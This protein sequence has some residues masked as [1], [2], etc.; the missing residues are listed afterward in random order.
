MP[1]LLPAGVFALEYD[2]GGT[3]YNGTDFVSDETTSDTELEQL[4]IL[5]L[6]FEAYTES[7][8]GVSGLFTAQGRYEYT[9]DRA[10]LFDIDVLKAKGKFPGALGEDS[11]LEVE[12]GRTYFS[13]P[14]GI[15]LAHN[16]DGI[17]GR[18]IYPGVRIQ[19]GSDIADCF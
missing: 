9:D 16:A 15:V 10:Y 11:V 5:S 3:F 6:M 4:N 7:E 13:D 2:Y 18:L 17:S 19:A 12:A 1:S 8:T 14:T